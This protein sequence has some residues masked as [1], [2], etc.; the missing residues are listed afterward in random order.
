MQF[1]A[2]QGQRPI[3]LTLLPYHGQPWR[4]ANELF[5]GPAKSGTTH[6]HAYANADLIQACQRVS[7]ALSYVRQG[8]D[9]ALVLQRLL[10]EAV[11]A[12][13]WPGLLLLGHGLYSVRVIRYP[14]AARRPTIASG[15][16]AAHSAADAAGGSH[17]T[18]RLPARSTRRTPDPRSTGGVSRS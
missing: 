18:L 6:F 16:A 10:A 13:A 3:D 11:Q 4:D 1:V 14:Q 17:R 9:L 2:A 15:S 8:E 7:L 12:G 5:R